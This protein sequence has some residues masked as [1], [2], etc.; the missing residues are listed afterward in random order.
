MNNTENRRRRQNSARERQLARER[1]RRTAM[2]TRMEQGGAAADRVRRWVAQ[3]TTDERL[4]QVAERGMLAVHDTWWYITRNPRT[5]FYALAGVLLVIVLYLANFAVSG[6]IFPNTGGLG[7]SLGGRSVEDAAVLLAQAWNDDMTID[8]LVEGETQVTVEPEEIGM[9]LDAQATAEAARDMGLN[10]FP[11]GREVEPVVELDYS[12]AQNYLLELAE[13]LEFAPRNATFVWEDGVV[14]GIP[15]RAGRILNVNLSLE[16]MLQNVTLV[17]QQRRF[18]LLVTPLP[19]DVIEPQPY[20]DDVEELLTGTFTLIGYD[21]FTNQQYTWPVDAATY[22]SWLE[23]GASSLTLREEAFIP[24]IDALTD[25]VNA[26]GEDKRYLSPTETIDN[27]RQAIQS[28]TGTVNLRIRYRQTVHEVVRGDTMFS[29]ARQYGVPY[30]MLL[31]SNTG[32]DPDVLSVGDQITVPTRDV[33]MENPPLTDKRIIVDLDRQYLVAF[34]NGQVR[35]EWPISSGVSN[36]PTSPGIYQILS[37]EEVAYGS[38]NTLC[39]SAGL[40]CGVWEMNWFMGIYR[41]QPQLVNGFHGSVLLPNG[42][43]LGGGAI[44]RPNTFGC[45]MSNDDNAR[46]LYE[47]AEIGTVVEI[48][49]SEFEPMSDLGW[50]VWNQEWR[51]S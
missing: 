38:S 20:L 37:H 1:R 41:V 16:Q 14:R 45:V 33:T 17:A 15:G 13:E 36:A 40:E 5:I 51:R 48:V 43:L 28:G 12:T 34:E 30:F 9:T 35:F 3:V 24:F 31:E 46:A 2:A 8:L 19:P 6:R 7:V 22:A 39:N 47:W 32:I 4:H 11:F 42:G 25:T 27:M 21:P 26:A 50:A 10:G 49:S 23:A 18:E 44:G 29:I